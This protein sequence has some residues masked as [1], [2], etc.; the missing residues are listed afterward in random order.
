MKGHL[1]GPWLYAIV[2]HK[3]GGAGVTRWVMVWE[4]DN[5]QNTALGGKGVSVRNQSFP[6]SHRIED[7]RTRNCAD[8][9]L[10]QHYH[11]VGLQK[12][13]W[14]RLAVSCS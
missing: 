10:E 7:R 4:E 13:V 1:P 8:I 11:C 14:V 6:F 2:S 5:K 9:L 12:S 3:G